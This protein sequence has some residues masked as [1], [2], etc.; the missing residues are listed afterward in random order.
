MLS[1]LSPFLHRVVLHTSDSYLDLEDVRA[2]ILKKIFQC[3]YLPSTL[4]KDLDELLEL[5][6]AASKLEMEHVAQAVVDTALRCLSTTNCIDMLT[7]TWKQSL[8]ALEPIREASLSMVLDEFQS[9]SVGSTFSDMDEELL[10]LIIDDNRL[11]AC[12]EDAVLSAV[13]AWICAR[14]DGAEHAAPR[15][16]DSDEHASRRSSGTD[17]CGARLLPLVRFGLLGE[18]GLDAAARSLAG[19][20]LITRLVAEARVL[21]GLPEDRRGSDL[22]PASLLGPRRGGRRCGSTPPRSERRRAAGR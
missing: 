20:P 22:G 15:S 17:A 9:L 2:G 1:L 18:G 11:Q 13:A 19:H 3:A 8:P 12:G 16:S 10:A 14:S 21:A 6:R 5:G 7:A 4:V